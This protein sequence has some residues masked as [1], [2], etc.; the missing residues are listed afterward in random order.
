MESPFIGRLTDFLDRSPTPWHAVANISELL[1]CAGF[2]HL[3][4][5]SAWAL[6]AGVAY[7]VVRSDGALVAWRQPSE[8]VG[9]TLF[10][11]HTDSPNLRV[12]PEPIM[13]KH[14]YFQLGLEVYGGVLLST[15]F[16]RDLSLAGRVAIANEGSMLSELVDFERAVGVI[17][18]LAIHLNRDANSGQKI[19]PQDELPMVLARA[20]KDAELDFKEL[21]ARELDR[22]PQDIAAFEICAY[23]VERA[24]VIGLERELLA[25]ARLDNLLSCFVVVEAIVNNDQI[26]GTMVVLNDHEEI[27][28][29]STSGADGPFLESILR[30]ATTGADFEQVRVNSLMVSID[31]AHGVHPN[32]ASKHDEGHRPLLNEGPVVKVN[33]NHRYATTALTQGIIE[34]AAEKADVPLQY[35]SSRADLGCGSTIGPLTAGRLGIDT[36]DLGCAQF[37]MHSA[38]ETCGVKDPELMLKLLAQLTLRDFI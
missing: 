29:V 17:P 19:N 2:V 33:A 11:A 16:D 37:A 35:F 4:E 27:G 38:R 36:I 6:E 9:W 23:P 14:G 7:F 8:V 31:N 12:R 3:D 5:R 18:H 20:E 30:R 21:L 22:L 13:K 34:Q 1:E 28:S 24:Q 10:G 15:W 25:S 26:Q 32:Y